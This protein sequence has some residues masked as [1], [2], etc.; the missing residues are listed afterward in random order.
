MKEVPQIE[1]IKYALRQ[2]KDGT[3]VSW[4]IHPEDVDR[5][6]QCL[7]IGARVM[8]GWYEIGDDEKP[9]AEN[10]ATNAAKSAENKPDRTPFHKLP[11]VKQAG[12]RCDDAQFQD[13]LKQR[14]PD[15][16]VKYSSGNL[17][18]EECAR[19]ILCNLCNIGSRS[20]LGKG[21]H[22]ADNKWRKLNSDYEAWMLDQKYADVRR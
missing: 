20:W 17:R 15:A 21:D 18:P 10:A 2:T 12:I 22:D 6:L 7:P 19:N 3:V 13:F 8:F 11:L 16:W 9:V 1:A 5:A 4:L 14:C